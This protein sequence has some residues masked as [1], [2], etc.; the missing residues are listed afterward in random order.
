MAGSDLVPRQ[1]RVVERFEQA[2]VDLLAP[3]HLAEELE[4]GVLGLGVGGVE[5]RLADGDYFVHPLGDDRRDQVLLAGEVAKQS[6]AP[7]AGGLGDLG[8]ADVETALAE[9]GLGGL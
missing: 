3:D 5:Q 4:Q 8:H 7:D 1:P 2:P 9:Q 6:A